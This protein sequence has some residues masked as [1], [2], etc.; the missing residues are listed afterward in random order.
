M[1]ADS[2]FESSEDL[3]VIVY[4]WVNSEDFITP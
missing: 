4:D 1:G 3:N 2:S